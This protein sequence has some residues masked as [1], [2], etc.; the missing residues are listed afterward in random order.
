MGEVGQ[1]PHASQSADVDLF[2]A[3]PDG[4]V[5]VDETGTI[6]A[7]NDQLGQMFGYSSSE[8][9]GEPIEALL[10]DRFRAGHGAHR[11]AYFKAPSRRPMGATLRLFGRKRTGEEFPV[12]ISLN[13]E[14]GRDGS[15]RAIAFVRDVTERHRLE[16]ELRATEENFRLLVEG[17]A[18]HALI[19]LDPSGCVVTWNPGAERIKGWAAAEIIGRDFA[20]FYV[21]EDV[22]SGLPARD[23]E[24]AAADGRTQDAG[25]RVRG[26]GKRFWAETTLSALRDEHGTLRGFAQG[27][28]RDRTESH[29]TRAASRR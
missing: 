13:Y 9:V 24:R 22:A 15:L 1:D 14:R 23:L 2:A 12:D 10:P 28:V 5:V 17:V 29:Q 26:D 25:W 7:A 18:D 16:E 11:K 20:V 19:M 21:P 3:A 6:T 4:I 27:D 8:L